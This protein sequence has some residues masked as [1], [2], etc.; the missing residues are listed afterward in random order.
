MDLNQEPI[1]GPSTMTPGDESPHIKGL[2]SQKIQEYRNAF[3]IFDK[4][5]NNSI[6]CS[7]LKTVLESLGKHP[8]DE[9]IEEMIEAVDENGNGE[10]EFEEFIEL[11]ENDHLA[12]SSENIVRQAF[13]VLAADGNDYVTMDNLKEMIAGLGLHFSDEDI[14]DMID[15]AGPSEGGQLQ[16]SDLI[17]LMSTENENLQKA[18]K[19]RVRIEEIEKEEEQRREVERQMFEAQRELPEIP[20]MTEIAQQFNDDQYDRYSRKVSKTGIV[21]KRVEKKVPMTRTRLA[22][23]QRKNKGVSTDDL[24]L[25][26][27]DIQNNQG[28]VTMPSYSSR[29]GYLNERNSEIVYPFRSAREDIKGYDSRLSHRGK[30]VER[31]LLD[32]S[33]YLKKT[34]E[35]PRASSMPLSIGHVSVSDDFEN[36]LRKLRGVPVKSENTQRAVNVRNDQYNRT[37]YTSVPSK[38]D[39][40]TVNVAK[41]P[42]LPNPQRDVWRQ[43][44]MGTKFYATLWRTAF[45]N[46]LERLQVNKKGVVHLCTP[47]LIDERLQNTSKLQQH[48]DT[49]NNHPVRQK[50]PVSVIS[51]MLDTPRK[52]IIPVFK[53]TTGVTHNFRLLQPPP[54]SNRHETPHRD[55]LK[56]HILPK[57]EPR[58]KRAE[59]ITKS[60]LN[61]MINSLST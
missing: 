32:P 10:I 19:K 3:N 37:N 11:M 15:E 28:G 53:H 1:P 22:Y 17:G 51:P 30:S 13:K 27:F 31:R 26:N 34:K 46:A 18:Y 33:Y 57:I 55:F 56:P 21:A 50:K 52:S 42:P 61:R 39:Q 2:S 16:Y 38:T 41:I 6:S 7:E 45:A 48:N 44:L 60:D 35:P 9:E 47:D 4:D 54:I 59:L 12:M 20:D 36:E 5:G 8:T 29:S 49:K 58:R 24:S 40:T 25:G 43:Q 14:Q 23:L